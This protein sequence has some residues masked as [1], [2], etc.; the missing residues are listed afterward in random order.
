MAWGLN[1]VEG[2]CSSGNFVLCF[3]ENVYVSFR[4]CCVLA[5]PCISV[6]CIIVHI[7]CLLS[8]FRDLFYWSKLMV[9]TLWSFYCVCDICLSLSWVLM[10]LWSLAGVWAVG[11][12]KLTWTTS[13]VLCWVGCLGVGLEV[14]G[15]A[16]GRAWTLTCPS[17]WQLR[18]VL[19]CPVLSGC[20]YIMPQRPR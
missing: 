17:W 2:I 3:L 4:G 19:F 13:L 7:Y 5:W 6:R 18:K 1:V 16:V 20:P 9:S 15:G 8:V 10:L 11:R 14:E 12:T